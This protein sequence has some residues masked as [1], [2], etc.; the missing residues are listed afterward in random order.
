MHR[1]TVCK[2]SNINSEWQAYQVCIELESVLT[3]HTSC[4]SYMKTTRIYMC[5]SHAYSH[6][7]HRNSVHVIFCN[8]M[9]SQNVCCF[10][11]PY[12]DSNCSLSWTGSSNQGWTQPSLHHLRTHTL[13]YFDQLTGL[14]GTGGVTLAATEE[15]DWE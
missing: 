12:S 13:S 5:S 1:D 4:V 7:I 3:Q 11:V 6:I 8:Q 9:P 15:A 2:C 10:W 14:G